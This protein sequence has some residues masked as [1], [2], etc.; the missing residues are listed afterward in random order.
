MRRSEA[1]ARLKAAEPDF[2]ARGAEGLYL[3][4]SVARDE[5]GAGSDVDVFIDPDPARRFGF[6]EFMAVYELLQERLGARIDYTT[7]EGLHRRLRPEIE[8]TAIRVF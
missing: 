8:K 2:R 5:A 4:G 1:I 6:D 7:R 3:F